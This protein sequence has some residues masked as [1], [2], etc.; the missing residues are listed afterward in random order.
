M[1]PIA[2]ATSTPAEAPTPR[3]AIVDTIG[4]QTSGIDEIIALARTHLQVFDIDLAQCGWDTR[5]RSERLAAF[6]RR[7]PEA[8][9]HLIV[10]NTRWLEQSAPLI[11]NLLQRHA[12]AMTVYRTGPEAKHAM[13][14]L[15][16]ADGRH[17]LHRFHADQPRAR[18]AIEQPQLAMPLRTRFEEIWATGEPGLTASV[19][20]L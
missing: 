9:L 14:P 16:I 3:D 2:M 1:P 7:N 13:D 12:E 19:L 10:H 18:L 6:L 4:A 11:R 20:G 8:R 17:F 15:V 5:A